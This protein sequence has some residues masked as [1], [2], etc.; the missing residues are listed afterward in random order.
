MIAHETGVTN[1]IDPLGGSYFVEALTDEM[2]ARAYEYFAKI[3]ELGGMVEAVKRGFPQREIAEASFRY[4][5]EVESGER[6]IVGVNAFV[7]EDEPPLEI[8]K[9]DAALEGKQVERVKA[10]REARDGAAADRRARGPARGRDRRAR[11]HHAA[12]ARGRARRRDR[13]RDGRDPPVRLRDLH[14]VPDLLGR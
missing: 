14:R 3:D 9:I 8:L 13:G 10:V 11:Q 1:T 12:A 5:Q 2:E 4:Q 7:Q 6:K